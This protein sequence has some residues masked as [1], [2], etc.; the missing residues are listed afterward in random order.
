M[1]I[2][3]KRGQSS[4]WISVPGKLDPGQL[5]IEYRD[6]KSPR[7]KVGNFNG[8][9]NFSACS[10]LSPDTEIYG[11]DGHITQIDS[12]KPIKITSKLSGSSTIDFIFASDSI[13]DSASGRTLGKASNPWTNI[14]A[15]EI[16]VVSGSTSTFLGYESSNFFIQ[17][18]ATRLTLDS[19][20]NLCAGA[21]D[22]SG[23]LGTSTNYW[24]SAYISA[25]TSNTVDTKTVKLNGTTVSKN[26]ISVSGD[27]LTLSSNILT[28]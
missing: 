26:A 20:M 25:V 18:G 17:M 13:Y 5:G 19:S 23:S 24:K 7:V 28:A 3:I 27:T 9:N 11:E 2:Q 4:N 22:T 6:G 14:Y 12:T 21:S 15:N 8:T 10:Y 1:A 16:T